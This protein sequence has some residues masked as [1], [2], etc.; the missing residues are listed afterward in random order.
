MAQNGPVG[1][2]KPIIAERCASQTM[3]NLSNKLPF[4]IHFIIFLGTCTHQA[5]LARIIYYPG[6]LIVHCSKKK[7]NLT[8][9][10]TKTNL[11]CG[12]TTVGKYNLK[13]EIANLWRQL[14][15]DLAVSATFYDVWPFSLNL[16]RSHRGLSLLF[17]L[18]KREKG[19][20]RLCLLLNF[21]QKSISVAWHQIDQ[22]PQGLQSFP[23]GW[24]WGASWQ[25]R[26]MKV[27]IDNK[28]YL[29]K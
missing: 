15:L 10:N 25:T 14:P 7:K 19:I 27:I 1:Q 6:A 3:E 16:P 26:G 12:E 24:S 9:N 18:N 21:S 5:R 8:K 2:I 20:E 11:P 22:I 28:A 23:T 4:N 17:W 29:S 13:P